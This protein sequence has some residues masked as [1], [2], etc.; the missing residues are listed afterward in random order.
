[1]TR[2]CFHEFGGQLKDVCQ[3]TPPERLLGSATDSSS[4]YATAGMV[5]LQAAPKA[6]AA[7]RTVETD[8]VI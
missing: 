4:A 7:H 8:S 2:L 3:G 1:M 5:G 6:T